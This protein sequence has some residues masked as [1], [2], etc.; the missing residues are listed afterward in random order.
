[1]GKRTEERKKRATDPVIRRYLAFNGY[2]R[3]TGI[4]YFFNNNC[5]PGICFLFREK[6]IEYLYINRTRSIGGINL[7]RKN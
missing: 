4:Y 2:F 1:M 5:T 7:I 6:N 3:A